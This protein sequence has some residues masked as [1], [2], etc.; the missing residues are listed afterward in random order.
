MTKQQ[1][2]DAMVRAALAAWTKALTERTG[3][4]A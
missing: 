2:S 1:I 4:V 3:K